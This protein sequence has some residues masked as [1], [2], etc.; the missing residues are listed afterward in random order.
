MKLKTSVFALCVAL[1]TACQTVEPAPGLDVTLIDLGFGEVTVLETTLLCTIR[2]QN[3]NPVPLQLEGAVHRLYLNGFYI[4]EGTVSKAS[5]VP[6]LGSTTQTAKV[7]LSNLSLIHR[8]RPIVESQKVDYQLKST[9]YARDD[10]GGR[11]VNTEAE[12]GL[13]L[14]DFKFPTPVQ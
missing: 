8:L 11:R 6:R 9:F 7:F 5:A 13:S 2:I 12:G 3:P 4:G 10:Q 14:N 1:L